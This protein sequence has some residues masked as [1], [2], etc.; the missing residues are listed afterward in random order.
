MNNARFLFENNVGF[1]LARMSEVN[2]IAG[3]FFEAPERL[4]QIRRDMHRLGRPHAASDIARLT[5]G[6]IY[7]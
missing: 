4:Q 7:E 1:K 3:V 5:I 6:T 2:Y